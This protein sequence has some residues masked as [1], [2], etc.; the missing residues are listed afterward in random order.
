LTTLVCSFVWKALSTLVLA[1]LPVTVQ[2]DS[3]GAI[4]G[5]LVAITA[6]DLRIERSS[7]EAVVPLEDVLSLRPAKIE[8]ATGPVIRVTLAGGSRIAAQGVTTNGNDLV[9][10]PRRQKELRVPIREAKA[11]RFR[12]GA[13]ATDPQWLGALEREGA[14]DTLVIRRPDNQLDP[15][16][17]IVDSITATEVVF[18][19]DGD[20]VNA[21]IDRLEGVIFGSVATNSTNPSIQITD[22]YGSQWLVAELEPS[23]GDQ[24]LQMR[25]SD[26]LLHELPLHQIE[27]ILW[28][29]G[30]ASLAT[31][32][33]AAGSFEPYIQTKLDP[34]L[35]Q[36]FFQAAP[37]NESD[38]RM[39]GGSAV[40]YRID[41][42]YQVLAGTVARDPDLTRV[43]RVTVRID[44][45]GEKAWEQELTGSEPLG[46]ELP[47]NESRRLAISVHSGPD[48]DLGDSVR[49][50]RLRLLK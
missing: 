32:L 11:I 14:G 3:G 16:R 33:P 25:L 34:Q 26:N 37:H 49:M 1:V 44:L 40:E 29:T 8:D 5:N 31:M 23:S 17:G 15:Q 21:P 38:L 39:F 19:L 50:I 10:E 27:S 30:S 22:I 20:K 45:D 42:G 46:F 41:P 2:T 4:E 35:A 36:A 43:S 24:P 9:I 12:A 48:G 6:S 18:D 7:G 28:S 13:A 47:L